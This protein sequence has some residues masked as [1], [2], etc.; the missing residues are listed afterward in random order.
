MYKIGFASFKLKK[1]YLSLESGRFEDKQLFEHI[2]QVIEL[3]RFDSEVGAKIKR[4][5]WPIK[6]QKYRILNLWK[7]NLPRGWRLVYTVDTQNG[8][9]SI[10][11]LEWFSHKEYEKRFNYLL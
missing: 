9:I 7:V 5:L 11:V 6:Y 1:E 10:A 8:V 2:S 4:R 3:L